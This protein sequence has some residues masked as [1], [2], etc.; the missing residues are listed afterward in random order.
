[1]R[2]KLNVIIT[3]ILVIT[4]IFNFSLK[5]YAEFVIA[6]IA[7]KVVATILASMGLL[8]FVNENGGIQEFYSGLMNWL[9]TKKGIVNAIFEFASIGVNAITNNTKMKIGNKATLIREYWNT[10]KW[11]VPSTGDPYEIKEGVICISDSFIIAKPNEVPTFANAQVI[12]SKNVGSGYRLD[13]FI[14]RT[15]Q[16]SV[17]FSIGTSLYYEG[18][19]V[20]GHIVSSQSSTPKAANLTDTIWVTAQ[21]QL[22]TDTMIQTV[23]VDNI[24]KNSTKT[25]VKSVTFTGGLLGLEDYP[26]IDRPKIEGVPIPKSVPLGLAMPWDYELLNQSEVIGK[27]IEELIEMVGSISLDSYVEKLGELPKAIIDSIEMPQ[28]IVDEQ[29]IITGINESVI[30]E[31]IPDIKEQTGILEGIGEGINTI[32]EKID[33]IFKSTEELEI[34]KVELDFSPL[35]GFIL[36]DKFPF[37]LP[38]DLTG[39]VNLL[40]APPVPP[41]FE[42]PILTETID[43]DFTQFESLAQISRSFFTIIFIVTLIILTK[44]FL[45]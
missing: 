17:N 15:T 4:I 41:K 44:K 23:T 21:V 16:S 35:S 5:P 33:N 27:N 29:G 24:T 9:E 42:L 25:E 26:T 32:T 18:Q 2:N 10:L 30:P 40:V 39:A 19:R 34:E 45:G 28:V 8:S 3:L 38:W 22:T 6:G 11:E 7:I 31:I 43:I 1:M 13:T 37:S 14:W 12:S 20:G 36:K